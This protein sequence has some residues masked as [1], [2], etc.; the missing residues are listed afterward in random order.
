MSGPKNDAGWGPCTPGRKPGCCSGGSSRVHDPPPPERFSDWLSNHRASA[1]LRMS[2]C[3]TVPSMKHREQTE[4]ASAKDARRSFGAINPS[5]LY[6]PRRRPAMVDRPRLLNAI[7]EGLWRPLTLVVAPAGSGKTTLVSQWMASSELPI[8]WLSLDTD[9]SDPLRFLGYLLATIR[10]I[11]PDVGAGLD[12]IAPI[13]GLS[14]LKPL[15]TDTVLVPLAEHEASFALVLD[16][17]HAVNSPVVDD[18]LAWL[19]EHLPPAMHVLI[20]TRQ[21][22]SL[23]LARWRARDQ[24]TEIR[25]P[26]LGFQSDEIGTFFNSVFELDL[27]TPALEK[28]HLQTEGW[29]AGLQLLGLSLRRGA[30]LDDV[31]DALAED[32]HIADYLVD[33]ILEQ[34]SEKHRDFMLRSSVLDE[35]SGPLCAAVTGMSDAADLLREINHQ[36]LFLIALDHRRVRYRFHHLFGAL[37]RARL[38]EDH[39]GLSAE[40]HALASGWFA[41]QGDPSNAAR[42]AVRANNIPLLAEVVDRWGIAVLYTSDMGTLQSWLSALPDASTDALPGIGALRAWLAVLPLRMPP[43]TPLAL[44]AVRRARDVLNLRIDDEKPEHWA[45]LPA[46]LSV[47]ESIATR[48][49][50]DPAMSIAHAQKALDALPTGALG[51]AS[52]LALQ[53]GITFGMMGQPRLALQRLSNAEKWGKVGGNAFAATAGMGYRSGALLS[54]GQLR[55]GEALCHDALA[56]AEDQ[57]CGLLGAT[58]YVYSQLGHIL[59]E[60]WDLPAALD[61]LDRGM[62]RARMLEDP[63][64]GVRMLTQLARIRQAGGEHDLADEA[65]N[66]AQTVADR[67]GIPMLVGWAHTGRDILNVLRGHSLDH[68][69]PSA[70]AYRSATHDA[71][72]FAVRS[73]LD[74]GGGPDVASIIEAHR[75]IADKAGRLAHVVDWEVEAA[76]ACHL[77]G[78]MAAAAAALERVFTKCRPVGFRR[79]FAER[80][81][82]V[83][84]IVGNL[85]PQAKADFA[86][87]CPTPVRPTRVP[88]V[89]P[90]QTGLPPLA[91]LPTARELEVLAL[92]GEGL[93]N[94]EIG[95]SLFVSTGTIKTHM[96]RVL[97]K[98]G[99]R[100]RVE[101]VN[102]GRAYG[103]IP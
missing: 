53:I 81:R 87:L 101:G 36:G 2:A 83:A 62:L 18:A 7:R 30:A 8:A 70:D 86:Q 14:D 52:V 43:N 15:I 71:P 76:I 85:S 25:G 67:S 45:N 35:L 82:G 37:L 3:C 27:E 11:C 51:A 80:A 1:S 48:P 79:V 13:S 98:L 66:E 46:H 100:N 6:A 23:P 96:H 47:A 29:A 89:R 78:D 20:T 40:L 39:P 17:Y 56:Y 92:A 77:D 60:R 49:V 10:R 68:D 102:S 44:D 99:A 42:H 33:E 64:T 58:A 94:P 24:I 63:F 31:L 59:F 72:L 88:S 9:D 28:L 50:R 55:E 16:D 19:V 54:L 61:A 69:L 32:E 12:G 5:K 75:A 97:G 103:F 90:A 41:S 73:V 74:G 34:I 91:V 84:L 65:A 21:Q 4:A 22:P 26:D 38:E 95:K 57:K 93:S